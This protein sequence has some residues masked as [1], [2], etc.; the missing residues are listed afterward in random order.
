MDCNPK[1]DRQGVP[2]H[3][4]DTASHSAAEHA[5]D[6]KAPEH[7]TGDVWMQQLQQPGHS[8]GD[9]WTLCI[10]WRQLGTATGTATLGAR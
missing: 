6:L 1:V 3:L 10:S 4:A 5:D 9:V 2:Q 7:S 8:T